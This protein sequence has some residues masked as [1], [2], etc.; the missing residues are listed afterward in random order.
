[1]KIGLLSRFSKWFWNE[2]I[3]LPPNITWEDIKKTDVI[4]Y[5]QFNDLYYCLLIAVVLLIVRF[6]LERFIFTPI[7]VYFGLKPSRPKRAPENHLLEKAFRVNGRIGY[8][9]IQGLAKQL[10]WTE[11]KVERWLRQRTLQDK[12][13]TLA[14][15]TESSWRFTF[16]CSIFAYGLYTLSD[17]PWLWDTKHCWYGY[18]HHSM[19]SDVWWYYMV[20]L[21]FYTSL[22]FSQF[23]DIKRKDFAQMFVHHIVTILLLV[24]SWSSN[25]TRIG[26]IVLIVH[27][28]ADCPLEAA[29]MA[30]YIHKQRLGD[31]LFVVFTLAWI[32]SRLGL[33][34]YRVI[35]STAFEAVTCTAM[36]PA[37]YI[38]NGLLCALQVLHIVWTWMIIRVALQAISSRQVKDI[39]SDDS[40]AASSSS[41]C[42]ADGN[43][44]NRARRKS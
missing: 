34:P 28:F 1:M 27:D 23:M 16:Y 3:W 6:T 29:K 21:G 42:N 32:V 31:M 12:P 39:R 44:N 19:T 11:R 40:S 41:S 30:K 9:Q 17:K 8:K 35:Y 24:F 4:K 10:D 22:T 5:A 14:K 18:P 15:F 20:E 25:L 26:T 33:Y 7:G 2:D 43:C 13:T 38:F 37:Y 36:F